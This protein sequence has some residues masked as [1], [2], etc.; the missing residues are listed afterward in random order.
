MLLNISNVPEIIYHYKDFLNETKNQTKNDFIIAVD[1]LSTSP[2]VNIDKKRNITGLLPNDIT[3]QESYLL[4]TLFDKFEKIIQS[5]SNK[6]INSL[7]VFTLHPLN[8]ELL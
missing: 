2:F 3:I 6:I 4:E 1:A 7:F 5:N 8:R